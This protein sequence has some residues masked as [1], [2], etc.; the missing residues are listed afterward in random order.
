MFSGIKPRLLSF[1]PSAFSSWQ[2]AFSACSV[3]DNRKSIAKCQL[4]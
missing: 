4:L 3:A 1:Q 2:L